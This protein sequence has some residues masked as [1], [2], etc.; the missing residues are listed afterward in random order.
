MRQSST[1]Q[2]FGWRWIELDRSSWKLFER[3]GWLCCQRQMP[4]FFPRA[5]QRTLPFSCPKINTSQKN[6]SCKSFQKEPAFAQSFKIQFVLF[7]NDSGRALSPGTFQTSGE[8]LWGFG[9]GIDRFECCSHHLGQRHCAL[10]ICSLWQISRLCRNGGGGGGARLG[11]LHLAQLLQNLITLQPRSC[12]SSCSMLK[13]VLP[14]FFGETFS[15]SRPVS[16]WIHARYLV[17]PTSLEVQR[18]FHP[19]RMVDGQRSGQGW[20]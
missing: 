16:A 4:N 17:C 12:G 18:W 15:V 13:S 19:G 1:S 14:G 10:G 11:T 20:V 2:C 8:G 5:A 3:S 7:E 9:C 6:L